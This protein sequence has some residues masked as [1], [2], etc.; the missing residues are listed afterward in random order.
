MSKTRAEAELIREAGANEVIVQQDEIPS[1]AT[2][3]ILLNKL[4]KKAVEAL[5]GRTIASVTAVASEENDLLLEIYNSIIAQYPSGG[6]SGGGV[7]D[8]DGLANALRKSN[9]SITSDQELDRM[10]A[11]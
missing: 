5:Q 1:S 3:L 2:A 6:F 11:W 7:V 8:A 9:R 10:E 4:S